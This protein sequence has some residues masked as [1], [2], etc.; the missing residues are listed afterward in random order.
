VGI[1][2]GGNSVTIEFKNFTTNNTACYITSHEIMSYD[3]E[4]LPDYLS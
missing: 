2:K 3:T 1:I 4:Y